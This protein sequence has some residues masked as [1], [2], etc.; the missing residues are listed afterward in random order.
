[1]EH[2]PH[3]APRLRDRALDRLDGLTAG[4]AALAVVATAGFGAVAAITTHVPGVSAS[5]TTDPANVGD[6]TTGP[7]DNGVDSVGGQAAPGDQTTP[8]TSSTSNSP[9]IRNV[10]PQANAGSVSSPTRHRHAST[11]GS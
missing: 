4:A 11:G 8:R 1:M 9:R 2:D 10:Q 7:V 5:D 6:D 3:H